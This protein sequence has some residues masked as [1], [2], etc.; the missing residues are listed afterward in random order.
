MA[1]V[2]NND[3]LEGI[4][5]SLGDR[6]VFRRFKNKTVVSLRSTF[7]TR[8]SVK[9]KATRNHFRD[10]STYAKQQLQDPERKAYYEKRAD[11]LNLPNAYTAAVAEYMRK[12]QPL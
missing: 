4:S 9:Q 1:I 5:G 7:T 10:A 12:P 2:R 3:V 8:E 6:L 11:L